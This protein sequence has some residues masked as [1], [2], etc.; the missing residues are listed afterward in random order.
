MVYRSVGKQ[1]K[2]CSSTSFASYIRHRLLSKCQSHCTCKCNSFNEY[3]YLRRKINVEMFIIRFTDILFNL[4]L[5]DAS[6][7]LLTIL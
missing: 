5:A 6:A 1:L 2:I 7:C 3:T 4:S